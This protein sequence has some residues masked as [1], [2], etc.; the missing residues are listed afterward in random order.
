MEAPAIVL[1]DPKYPHN[2]GAAI[3]ACSCFEVNS[4]LWTGTRVNPAKYER[5]PREERLKGY[6][7]VEFRN[8]ERPFEMLPKE[9]TP[10][11]VEVFDSSEPLTTF[12]H[13]ENAVYV[14]GP[15]D[16]YVPQVIR[17]YCHRFVH[18][19]ARFCLNLSAAVNVVLAHRLMTRQLAGREP[20]LPLREMLR[21]VRGRVPTPVMDDVGWDGKKS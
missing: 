10:V 12:D 21:E 18:I 7:R 19:P 14:F 5:L 9:S 6:R 2:V 16:G 13:P 3:R 1:I 15:E 20:I 4:L 11:C 8:C 17:R